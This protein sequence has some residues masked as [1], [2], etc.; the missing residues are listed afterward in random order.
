MTWHR[1]AVVRAVLRWWNAEGAG[2]AQSQAQR[3]RI[4]V[5]PVRPEVR[6]HTSDL[7]PEDVVAGTEVQSSD[8]VARQRRAR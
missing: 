6:V 7:R 3:P 4:A 8:E 5:D 1:G 2:A